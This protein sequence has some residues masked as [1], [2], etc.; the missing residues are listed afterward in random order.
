MSSGRALGV[1]LLAGA[2]A[3]LALMLLWLAVSGAQGGGIVLGLLLILLLAGPLAGGGWYVLSRQSAEQASAAAFATRRRVLDSDRVFRAEIGDALNR[4]AARPGLPAADLHGLADELQGSAHRGVAWEETVQLDD[5]GLERLSRYDDLVRERVRRLRDTPPEQAPQ[6]MIRELRQALDQREDLLL[7][8]R[9]APALD[10]AQLLRA[11]AARANSADLEQLA[12]GDAVSHERTDYVVESLASYFAEGQTWKLARLAPTGGE[13]PAS[14]LY[15]G[16]GAI[17]VALMSEL[18]TSSADG[19]PDVPGAQLA[20]AGAGTAVVDVSSR[21]GN[22]RG[23]L[24]AYTKYRDTAHLALVEQWPD[25]ARRGY[26]GGLLKRDDLQV[27][28]AV[29]S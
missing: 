18:P 2:A 29:R 4:L 10:A 28:P 16:P 25:G 7:R 6:S 24:V 22:A 9:A 5:A 1:G 19:P 13:V 14:W 27:W 23:V 3:I 11:D 26:G 21:A 12:L 8:G 17:D 15:I 20:Q